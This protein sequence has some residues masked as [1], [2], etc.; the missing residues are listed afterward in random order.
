MPLS[1]S[2]KWFGYGIA[3]LFLIAIVLGIW[4]YRSLP[5]PMGSP[6]VLQHELFA[7]PA[8]MHTEDP[9]FN[10]H[11]ATELAA[12]IRSGQA[13]STEITKAFIARIKNHNHR[14]NALVWLREE[15]ALADAAAADAAVARGDTSLGLLHGVPLTI[16]EQFW[17]KGSPSTLNSRQFG[18]VAPMDGALVQQLKRAGA[19]IL[20]TTNVPALLSDYQTHG[21]IYPTAN[22][23]YDTSRTPGGSS[24]GGAAAVAVGFTAGELGSDMGGSI[25]VPAAF[26]GLWG[27]K[28]SYGALNQT[29][30]GWPDTTRVQRHLAMASPGP[31]TRTPQDLAL[32]WN[33]LKE[34]PMDPM[35]QQPIHRRSASDRPLHSYRFAWTADWKDASYTAHVGKD[36][37]RALNTLLHTLRTQGATTTHAV[38]AIHADLMRCFF[39]TFASVHGE[40]KPWLLRKLMSKGMEVLDPGTGTYHAYVDALNDMTEDNWQRISRERERLTAIWEKFFEEHDL[41]ILPV[42]YGPAFSKCEL[43]SELPGDHGPLRY[44]A[45]VPF[46]GVINATGHPTLSVPMGLNDKGLPVGLQIVGPMHSEEELLHLAL[47]LEPLVPGFIAPKL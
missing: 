39:A 10:F 7:P 33:V 14:Y 34:T 47:L 13:T 5:A 21:D 1:T 25:R 16:K 17:V 38:P 41:M 29:H 24:G 35:H 37:V 23:P 12:M 3:T 15:E 2:P 19:I 40:D 43:G 6:V 46:G 36:A 32:L 11:S 8:Q 27:L 30:G 4:I 44:M 22:N 28:P 42:T 26:C 18:F 31:L 9:R 20:G 45:Y